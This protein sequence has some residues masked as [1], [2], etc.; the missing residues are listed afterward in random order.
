M[1]F[2]PFW[3]DDEE[4]AERKKAKKKAKKKLKKAASK[5]AS[6]YISNEIGK[7]QDD[8]ATQVAT[9][10]KDLD[11]QSKGLATESAKLQAFSSSLEEKNRSVDGAISAWNRQQQETKVSA[12]NQGANQKYQI[13]T[14]PIDEKGPSP[15]ILLAAAAAAFFIFKKGKI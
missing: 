8:I 12:S 15:V 7:A 9:A 13:A 14:Q 11:A 5:I 10:Q 6:D 3:E 4:E 1:G 2:S